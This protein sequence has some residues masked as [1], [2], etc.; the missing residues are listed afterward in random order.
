MHEYQTIKWMDPK[1]EKCGEE[2]EEMEVREKE[3]LN[4]KPKITI[5]SLICSVH[6]GKSARDKT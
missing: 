3:G 5:T 1:G 4:P 6:N 2:T